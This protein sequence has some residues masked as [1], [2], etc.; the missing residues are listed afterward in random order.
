MYG[1][2]YLDIPARRDPTFWYRSLEHAATFWNVSCY[3]MGISARSDVP[4][5]GCTCGVPKKL[6]CAIQ[7]AAQVAMGGQEV[8]EREILSSLLAG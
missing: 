4:G 1:I 8:V 6:E 5:K 7:R 3:G 2:K